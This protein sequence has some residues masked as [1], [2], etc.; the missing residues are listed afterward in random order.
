MGE[1]GKL[2]LSCS[3]RSRYSPPTHNGNSIKGPTMSKV[4]SFFLG[5]VV[6]AVGLYCATTYHV[7]R[8]EDGVHFVPKVSSGVG[9]AYV[10]IR[11]FNTAQWHEHKNVALA[12][13]NAEKGDLMTDSAIADLR[14]N[15]QSAL[16]SLGLK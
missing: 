1:E 12:L 4:S 8:A 2:V 5:V 16:E 10:D 15:A 3:T 6:G 13:I 9:N 11:E 14:H 7:V